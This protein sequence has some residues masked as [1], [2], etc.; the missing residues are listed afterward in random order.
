M[1]LLR[2]FLSEYSVPRQCCY[3]ER[4]WYFREVGPV[5]V[6]VGHFRGGL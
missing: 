1:S 6:E 2:P 4:V 3:F 5:L